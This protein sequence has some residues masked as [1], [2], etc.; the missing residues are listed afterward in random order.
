MK[1]YYNNIY[2]KVYIFMK[3]NLQGTLAHACNPK[4]LGLTL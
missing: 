2:L 3:Q 4:V 1:F